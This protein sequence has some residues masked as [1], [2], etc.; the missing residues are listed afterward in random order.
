MVIAIAPLK[1]APMAEPD[2]GDFVFGLKRPH[3]EMLEFA[4]LVQNVARWRDRVGPRKSSLSLSRAPAIM[5]QANAWLP[6]T[7]R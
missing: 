6:V 2:G 3:A 5:P 4:Q 1:A 7:L